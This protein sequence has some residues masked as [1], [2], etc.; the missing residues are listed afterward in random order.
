MINVAPPPLR[1]S[2]RRRR[3]L[4]IEAESLSRMDAPNK[5]PHLKMRAVTPRPCRR[6]LPEDVGR[7]QGIQA[8]IINHYLTFICNRLVFNDKKIWTE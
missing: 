7:H 5:S 4:G 2:L 1:V 6:G 3:G 8:L